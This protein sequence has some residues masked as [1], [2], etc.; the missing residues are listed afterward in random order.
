GSLR[1]VGLEGGGGPCLVGDHLRGFFGR[2]QVVIDAQ[3]RGALAREG[4][5]RRA[6]V[7]DAFAG[8]LAGS[9]DD[10]DLVLQTH[11]SPSLLPSSRPER[12]VRSGGTFLVLSEERPFDF[13]SLRSAQGDGDYAIGYCCRTSL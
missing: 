8:A 2:L 10:R 11:F 9:D 4:D 3:N 7:A 1:H 5:R 6:A 13:A 12:V